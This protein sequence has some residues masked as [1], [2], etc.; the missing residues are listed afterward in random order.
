[1]LLTVICVKWIAITAVNLMTILETIT[2]SLPKT[3]N[4]HSAADSFNE[5]EWNRE[6]GIRIDPLLDFS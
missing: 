6:P 2:T 4:Q 3:Q 5:N 1:M